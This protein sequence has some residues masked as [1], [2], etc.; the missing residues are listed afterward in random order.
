VPETGKRVYLKEDEIEESMIIGS[1]QRG[2]RYPPA[3]KATSRREGREGWKQVSGI[4]VDEEEFRSKASLPLSASLARQIGE[5]T[6]V[7]PSS[8][9]YGLTLQAI[10]N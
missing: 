2:R 8:L 5:G 7:L 4:S 3:G 9:I 1:P 6:S 10:L